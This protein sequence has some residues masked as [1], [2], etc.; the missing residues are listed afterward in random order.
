MIMKYDVIIN[1]E[2]YLKT[3]EFSNLDD[4]VKFARSE[5]YLNDIKVIETLPKEDWRK[6][7]SESCFFQYDL[8]AGNQDR[9]S[10]CVII[11]SRLMCKSFYGKDVHEV[12]KEINKNHLALT[13]HGQA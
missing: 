4:A 3:K 10:T 2:W 9:D 1:K 13:H 7:G 11:Q 5:A 12:E 8:T 6:W